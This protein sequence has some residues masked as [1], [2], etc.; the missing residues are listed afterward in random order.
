MQENNIKNALDNGGKW[1]Q[2]RWKKA[3][4]E[5]RYRLCEKA[6]NLCRQY[7]A[8]CIINDS[9]DIALQTDAD[10]VHL[11]LTDETVQNARKI[12]G[13]NKIVGGTANTY[14]DV[15]QRVQEGCD[16]IGLGPFRFTATKENLSPILGIAGFKEIIAK[17]HEDGIL[18]P[19]VFAIGGIMLTDVEALRDAGIYGVAL[20]G[21]ITNEP[22]LV[23][24][25]KN[26]LK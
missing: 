10:G 11:G 26:L 19:P 4:Q 15:L 3:T 9:A 1:I 12:L 7:Q 17:L 2:V 24:N 25:F 8:V 18:Y 5:E 13:K 6:V 16:Y 14:E 21:V 22:A 20:S 23:T